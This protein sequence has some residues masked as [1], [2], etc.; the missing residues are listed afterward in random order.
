MFKWTDESVV[1]E[2]DDMKS[3]YDDK[4]SHLELQSQKYEDVV[5]SYEKKIEDLGD[6]W[7]GLKMR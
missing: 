4:I 3:L 7:L 1:E 2:I 6:A 5:R